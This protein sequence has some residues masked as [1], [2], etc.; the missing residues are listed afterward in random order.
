M[1]ITSSLNNNE[2]TN[3]IMYEVEFNKNLI[4][5]KNNN[6]TISKKKIN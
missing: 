5:F 6:I 4:L 2:I 3:D 1:Y